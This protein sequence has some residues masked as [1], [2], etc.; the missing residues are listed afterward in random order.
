V[1]T[2]LFHHYNIPMVNTPIGTPREPIAVCSHCHSLSC[3]WHG[4]LTKKLLYLC[5]LCST[6]SLLTGAM[7]RWFND[8]GLQILP[9]DDGE[10]AVPE[11]GAA[12]A[13]HLALMLGSLFLTPMGTPS[14]FVATTLR[15]WLDERPDYQQLMGALL[16]G[17]MAEYAVSI[18]NG[19]LNVGPEPAYIGQD[20]VD[21]SYEDDDDGVRSLW[22]RLDHESRLMVAAAVILMIALDPDQEALRRR[23]PEAVAAIYDRLGSP[24]LE[25][26]AIRDFCQYI[27]TQE[28]NG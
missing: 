7:S 16:H 21:P 11:G 24:L 13:Y 23:L 5:V 26:P 17:G 20:R 8:I 3:G 9:P 28:A 6:S 10:H 19:F 25:N 12:R 1:S 27:I 2:C 22:A 4:V 14:R 18:I 15:Q